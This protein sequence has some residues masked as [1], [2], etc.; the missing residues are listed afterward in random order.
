[1]KPAL[2]P[3]FPTASL[4]SA[5][6]MHADD[7][8]CT[9]PPTGRLS[10]RPAPQIIAPSRGVTYTCAAAGSGRLRR[11]GSRTPARPGVRGETAGFPVAPGTDRSVNHQASAIEKLIDLLGR[12]QLIAPDRLRQYVLQRGGPASLPVDRR[13]LFA[14]LVRDGLLTAYQGGHLAAGNLDN[15][16]VGKYLLLERL[17]P[18]GSSVYRAR[19][20]P[21]GPDVAI[22]LLPADES[23]PAAVERFPPGGR[24]TGSPGPSGNRRHQGIRRGRGSALPRHQFYPGAVAARDCGPAG[25]LVSGL[26]IRIIQETLQALRTSTRP[27]W[28]IATCG[29][30]T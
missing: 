16:L 20:R 13:A 15:L 23:P 19:K 30:A 22:K 4:P 10:S 18:V 1:M 17:G 21:S 2:P 7:P 24:G 25:P 5:A 26:A 12:E 27:G 14:D 8:T 11:P 9:S 6:K 3:S 29:R 28:C